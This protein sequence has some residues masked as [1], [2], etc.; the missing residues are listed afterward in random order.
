MTSSMGMH[1]MK[2]AQLAKKK[3]RKIQGIIMGRFLDNPMWNY[4]GDERNVSGTYF[5]RRINSE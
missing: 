2:D 1:G 4:L 3:K 5:H